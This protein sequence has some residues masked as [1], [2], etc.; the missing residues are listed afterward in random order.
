[1]IAFTNN[2]FWSNTF[3]IVW[4]QSIFAIRFQLDGFL[5]STSLKLNVQ[6]FA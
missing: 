4:R 5:L 3:E 2:D 1:M 6:A